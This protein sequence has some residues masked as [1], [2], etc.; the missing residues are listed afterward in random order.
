[1]INRYALPY[2]EGRGWGGYLHYCDTLLRQGS[3][4]FT[5]RYGVSCKRL[6]LEVSICGFTLGNK[7]PVNRGIFHIIASYY[8]YN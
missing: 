3:R 1:M 5:E 2:T 4:F 7:F 6:I 8:Y